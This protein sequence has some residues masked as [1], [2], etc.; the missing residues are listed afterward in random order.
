ME[1][2]DFITVLSNVGTDSNTHAANRANQLTIVCRG[3]LTRKTA[4]EKHCRILAP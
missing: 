2:I 3:S 4:I 1:R